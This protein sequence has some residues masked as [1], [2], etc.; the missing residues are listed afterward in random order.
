MWYLCTSEVIKM[1]TQ[2]LVNV[3]FEC[4]NSSVIDALRVLACTNHENRYLI[5]TVKG[6]YYYFS[7][8]G[9]SAD[10][11]HFCDGLSSKIVLNCHLP[12]GKKLAVSWR[13]LETIVFDK[14]DKELSAGLV[15]VPIEVDRFAGFLRFVYKMYSLKGRLSVCKRAGCSRLSRK[16]EDKMS[17][18]KECDYL[19][20]LG[21]PSLSS[22]T[23]CSTFCKQKMLNQLPCIDTP[24]T[25]RSRRALPNLADLLKA[26]RER[27][28]CGHSNH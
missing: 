28:W 2:L 1:D 8:K 18:S 15:G 17:E 9:F 22:K 23:V 6:I 19:D 16:H 7:M 26:A 3:W 5:S 13:V 27:E 12:H 24:V 10:R 11:L 25:I 4:M 21:F 20:A 14:T